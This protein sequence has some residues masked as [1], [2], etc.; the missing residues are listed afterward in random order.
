LNFDLCDLNDG[1]DLNHAVNLHNQ[2]NH[3]SRLLAVYEGEDGH[4]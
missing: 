2:K 1:H 3:S 4:K